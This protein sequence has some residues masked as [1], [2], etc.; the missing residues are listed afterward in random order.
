MSLKKILISPLQGKAKARVIISKALWKR[1]HVE[2]L[3]HNVLC[4]IQ[5]LLN[6]YYYYYYTTQVTFANPI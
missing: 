5:E 4:A 6:Y 2:M 3:F 1:I